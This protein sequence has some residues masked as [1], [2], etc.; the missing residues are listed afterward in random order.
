[1]IGGDFGEYVSGPMDEAALTQRTVEF[2]ADRVDQ[3]GG[4]VGGFCRG[5]RDCD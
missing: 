4:A 2:G 5:G 3:S 1:M